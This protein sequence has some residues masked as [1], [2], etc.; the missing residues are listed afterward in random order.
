MSMVLAQNRSRLNPN[1]FLFWLFYPSEAQ[2]STLKYM[3]LRREINLE[4]Q[5]MIMHQLN[6]YFMS[7]TQTHYFN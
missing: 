5:Q 6:N 4:S 1:L 2:A 3:A 7:L